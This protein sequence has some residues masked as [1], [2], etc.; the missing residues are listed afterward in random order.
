MK[1]EFSCGECREKLSDYQLEFTNERE[2]AIIEKHLES[3]PECRAELEE[4]RAVENMLHELDPVPLP[5][6]FKSNLHRALA[7][8]GEKLQRQN[9]GFSALF[10]RIFSN[11]RVFV[12]V[13][14]ALVLV[15]VFSTGIY[16]LMLNQNA[17]TERANR[18]AH[19]T[20]V[21]SGDAAENHGPAVSEE[22]TD[23]DFASEATALPAAENK[24]GR[25]VKPTAEGR[26]S[27]NSDIN[28]EIETGAPSEAVSEPQSEPENKTAP[29]ANENGA[30]DNYANNNKANDSGAANGS[31]SEEAAGSVSEAEY[32]DAPSV[33]SVRI[34][35]DDTDKTYSGG[36]SAPAQARG[37]GSASAQAVGDVYDVHIKV[38]NPEAMLKNLGFFDRAAETDGGYSL[39]LNGE[40]Y[41][42][43]I[44]SLPKRAEVTS[45]VPA[46]GAGIAVYHIIIAEK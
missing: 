29:T 3:C 44:A 22:P 19:Y 33:T 15:A 20:A 9:R 38:R 21:P 18:P 5:S 32:A 11:T 34:V 2:T 46:D 30:N 24:S 25:E 14:T 26:A 13:L 7:A 35:E 8:E 36:G 31:V 45:G 39:Y 6:D 12:P 28:G 27:E 10:G 43:F 42:S 4:L 41:R 17:E 40:E 23:A 1:K 16:E 37:G